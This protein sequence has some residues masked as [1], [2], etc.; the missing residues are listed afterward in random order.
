MIFVTEGHKWA[1]FALPNAQLPTVGVA[2]L[3][4]CP[5]PQISQCGPASSTLGCE[6]IVDPEQS[7]HGR[8]GGELQLTAKTVYRVQCS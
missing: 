2:A 7:G 1:I 6:D 4:S 3:I 5:P 8:C